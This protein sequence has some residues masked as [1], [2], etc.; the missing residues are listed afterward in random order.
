VVPL[1]ATGQGMVQA[2]LIFPFFPVVF[3]DDPDSP[4]SRP[5]RAISPIPRIPITAAIPDSMIFRN[6]REAAAT[7]IHTAAIN[8]GLFIGMHGFPDSV[9]TATRQPQSPEN[10]YSPAGISSFS[11]S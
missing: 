1:P 10:G 8:R 4:Y 5:D 9:T 3:P 6:R 11:Q 2:N 7:A